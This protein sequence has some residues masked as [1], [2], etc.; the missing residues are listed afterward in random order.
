MSVDIAVVFTAEYVTVEQI[1]RIVRDQTLTSRSLYLV[2]GVS[3]FSWSKKPFFTLWSDGDFDLN[4]L[5][6]ELS[7]QVSPVCLSWKSEHG[8]VGGYG[9]FSNGERLLNVA[10]TGENYLFLPSRGLEETFGVQLSLP[11]DANERLYFPEILLE[12]DL[13]CY[14]ISTIDGSIN[15][16]DNNVILQLLE[17]DLDGVEPILP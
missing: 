3:S 2:E 9:V 11:L 10:E 4:R 15:R 8:A 6:E 16:L 17:G 7:A 12:E 5:C 1:S 13:S 14:L